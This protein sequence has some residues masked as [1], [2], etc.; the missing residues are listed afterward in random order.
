MKIFILTVIAFTYTVTQ[1]HPG[2]AGGYT[3]EIHWIKLSQAQEKSKKDGKPLFI[4]VEAEW[5]GICKRMLNSVFPQKGITELLTNNFHPVLIDLDSRNAIMFNGEE[6]SER[7]FARNMQVQQTPTM[8]FINAEGEV[9]GRQ[10]GF[11]DQDELEKLL[12]YVLSD[13]FG[14]VPFSEFQ[15]N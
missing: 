5:C 8:I 15:V 7:N 9:M 3:N 11:M 2:G 12:H 13:E 4:F 14:I 6:I 10:P 1:Y